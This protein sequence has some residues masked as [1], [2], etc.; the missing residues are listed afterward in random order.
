MN[1]WA[2]TGRALLCHSSI[3]LSNALKKSGCLGSRRDFCFTLFAWLWLSQLALSGARP[4]SLGSI[5]GFYICCNLQNFL[6]Y[7]KGVR[8][9]HMSAHSWPFLLIR[10]AL[11][12]STFCSGADRL[13]SLEDGLGT[14][15]R[16]RDTLGL[17]TGAVGGD[18]PGT[19]LAPYSND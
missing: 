15:Q 18:P 4:V 13:F 9:H 17:A 6:T 1:T 3:G 19:D 8:P 14:V 12:V 5:S 16:S 2:R 10:R 11:Q 7:L